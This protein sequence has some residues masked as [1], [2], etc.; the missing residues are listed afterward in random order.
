MTTNKPTWF[1]QG[2]NIG[3]VVYLEEPW[4]NMKA[5][6]KEKTEKNLQ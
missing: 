3:L 1:Q 4:T 5:E 6:K 2:P